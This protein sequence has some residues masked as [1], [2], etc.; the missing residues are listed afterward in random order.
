MACGQGTGGAAKYP[1]KWHT[2]DALRQ[3]I[4]NDSGPL[5]WPHITASD[6]VRPDDARRK[7]DV[8]CKT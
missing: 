6:Q 3:R 4:E 5:M 1:V 8:S 7:L 2:L